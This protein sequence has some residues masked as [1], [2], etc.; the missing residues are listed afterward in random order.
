MTSLA[1]VVS[2][3]KQ[4]QWRF[5]YAGALFLGLSSVSHAVDG[6]SLDFGVGNKTQLIRLGVQWMWDRRWHQSEE[7]HI[8][9]YWDLTV[10][11]WRNTRYQNIPGNK[12]NFAA[13]GITPVFRI[14]RNDL[15]GLYGEAGIG[16]RHLFDLYNNNGR[17]L[18]THFQF[19]SHLGV[20]YMFDNNLDLGLRIQHVSNA[21]IKRPNSGVD[22]IIVRTSYRF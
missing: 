10:A 2:K 8:G 12:Q 1:R 3:L 4:V 9:G 11:Q 22:L 7:F 14:Q 6:V 20:G 18:S 19:A 17:R 15:T 13:I 16:L 5:V 21:S